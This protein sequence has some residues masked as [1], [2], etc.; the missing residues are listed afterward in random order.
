MIVYKSFGKFVSRE[1]RSE[2]WL[3]YRP[4]FR[5]DRVVKEF[6]EGRLLAKPIAAGEVDL[7]MKESA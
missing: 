5:I 3:L 4:E 2:R 1:N 7:K 6:R